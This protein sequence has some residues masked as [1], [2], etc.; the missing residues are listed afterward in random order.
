[1]VGVKNCTAW[2]VDNAEQKL[3]GIRSG[4][5]VKFLDG[6]FVIIYPDATSQTLTLMSIFET[7]EWIPDEIKHVTWNFARNWME[8]D[9]GKNI[10]VKNNKEYVIKGGQLREID[11]FTNEHY[12]ISFFKVELTDSTWIIKY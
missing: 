12:S 8:K 1:M 11:P 7:E 5:L 6:R 10:A 2:L 3:R 4:N 9:E